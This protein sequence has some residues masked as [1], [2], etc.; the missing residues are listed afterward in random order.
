MFSEGTIANRATDLALSGGNPAVVLAKACEG[1]API[2]TEDLMIL[3]FV[4]TET[5]D[6]IRRM[7]LLESGLYPEDAWLMLASP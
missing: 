4:F 5:L 6:S 7:R 2:S 3:N 1:T